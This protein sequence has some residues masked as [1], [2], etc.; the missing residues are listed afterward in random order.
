M[1]NHAVKSNDNEKNKVIE[2]FKNSLRFN[3][4]LIKILIFY[5]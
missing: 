2:N 5:I 1:E 3:D 4:E